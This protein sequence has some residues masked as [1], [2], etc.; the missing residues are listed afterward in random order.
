MIA[1]ARL[2]SDVGDKSRNGC[3]NKIKCFHRCPAGGLGYMLFKSMVVDKVQQSVHQ[4]GGGVR[5]CGPF[6]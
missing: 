5:V 1:H 4:G 3:Q 6:S 2:D